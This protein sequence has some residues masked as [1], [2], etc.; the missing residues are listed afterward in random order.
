MKIIDMRSDTVTLPTEEMR[1]AM[2]EAEVGDDVYEDD[3]TMKELEQLGA[4][5]LGKEAG[6]FVPS[7]TFGNQLAL[8]THCLRGDEVILE[9]NSHIIEHEVGG[10]A[11][12][13]GVQ[14]RTVKGKN[15]AMNPEDVRKVIREN[16]I[17]YPKTG[18]ICMENAHS[19]GAVLP[20]DNMRAIYKIGIEHNI[21]VHID[22]ARIFNA[23]ISLG[24]DASEVAHY[25]DSINLCLSKGLAAPVGSLLIGSKEFIAKARK[26]RKLM[27]GGMRQAG[28]LAASGIVA[29]NKMVDRLREDHENAKLFAEEISKMDKINVKMDRLDINMVYFEIQGSPISSE[30]LVEVLKQK[31][32]K[33]N[34]IDKGEYRFVTNKDVTRE[35]VLYVVE[36]LKEIVK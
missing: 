35:D 5:L 16:D 32:I 12:I 15:G 3:P 36:I 21:P 2:C 31:G 18:L 17:H 28:I 9:E 23:A 26:N 33:I 4:R 6:L 34:G 13:A 29:L 19:C 20:L 8:L 22:G 1:R 25:G 10:S 24:V 27:G 7:G 11:V 14:L 30:E